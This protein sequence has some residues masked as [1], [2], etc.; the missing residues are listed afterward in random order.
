[1]RYVVVK[2]GAQ[3]I[4]ARQWLRDSGVSELHVDDAIEEAAIRG[5][6]DEGADRLAPTLRGE[7][8]LLA[9]RAGDH[10]R[11]TALYLDR[12][13]HVANPGHQGSFDWAGD[14]RQLGLFDRQR[15]P[16]PE[17]TSSSEERAAFGA[18]SAAELRRSKPKAATRQKAEPRTRKP[19][20]P[21][22][23]VIKLDLEGEPDRKAF[24]AWCVRYAMNGG[25][26]PGMDWD[27]GSEHG[28][29][30]DRLFWWVK[31]WQ[32]QPDREAEQ[33]RRFLDIYRA[34]RRR[35]STFEQCLK[36]EWIDRARFTD[37][38][39]AAAHAGLLHAD[40][41]MF[42]LLRAA[43]KH[44]DKATPARADAAYLALDHAW[45]D[46]LNRWLDVPWAPPK[47]NPEPRSR[48]A[49]G[50]KRAAREA[51]QAEIRRQRQEQRRAREDRAKEL[52][53]TRDQTKRVR[54]K[55][56]AAAQGR[57]ERIRARAWDRIA[58]ADAR[59]AELREQ[60]AWRAGKALKRG[61]G[62]VWEQNEAVEAEL[63]HIDPLLVPL[64]RKHAGD[65]R[66]TP[67]ER[68]E[69]FLEWA[70]AQSEGDIWDAVEATLPTDSQLTRNYEAWAREQ[71]AA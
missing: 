6:L 19:K 31:A 45:L 52:G 38:R 63:R 8:W 14:P 51:A 53:Q 7:Q 58:R 43:V 12:S 35:G 64:W 34:E 37:A 21:Y 57:R 40:E 22:G 9:L 36:V 66:G 65:F 69:A 49:A 32:S 55:V 33:W 18:A 47:R 24:K 54:G 15:I 68:T 26:A 71:G 60:K 30:R 11:A 28:S 10:S 62:R 67:H 42:E 56:T 1:V 50:E 17:H 13:T 41:K 25:P 48:I 16:V 3:T 29:A 20:S 5:I 23:A 39:N 59:I 46:L 4:H 27:T 44:A 2:G 70:E 61:H